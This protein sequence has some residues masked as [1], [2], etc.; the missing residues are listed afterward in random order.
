MPTSSDLLGPTGALIGA[1]AGLVALARVIQI[2]WREHLKADAD[3]R[4][5]RD[6]AHALAKAAV[7]A[8]DRLADAWEQRNRDEAARQRRD[9]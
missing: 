3:D 4:E 2:L 8:Y 6:V 5:Q 9:D 1:V 7:A